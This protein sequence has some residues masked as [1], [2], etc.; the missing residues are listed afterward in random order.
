MVILATAILTGLI[1][2][3]GYAAVGR[4]SG[5]PGVSASGA[6]S[7]AIPIEVAGGMNGL[8][9]SV[10]LVYNSQSGGY[11]AGAGWSLAGFSAIT[12]C[13]HSQALDTRVR[14]VTFSAEDRFCLDGAPLIKKSSGTYGGNDEEYRTEIHN[15]QRI[16]SKGG[17][18]SGPPATFE[19]QQPNGLTY[20]YGGDTA[21]VL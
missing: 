9:P 13:G 8:K 19:V 11:L 10:A 21:T 5:Q 7:Y 12:R 1:A 17:G 2:P 18:S 14:G 6:A 16:V 15:Y 20:I 3:A 4:L